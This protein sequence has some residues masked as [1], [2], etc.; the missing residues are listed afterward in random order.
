MSELSRILPHLGHVIRE[1]VIREDRIG[2]LHVQDLIHIFRKRRIAWDIL[3]LYTGIAVYP[4]REVFLHRGLLSYGTKISIRK[5]L[6]CHTLGTVLFSPVLQAVSCSGELL[7][8]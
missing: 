7:A 3:S 8:E 5:S 6:L 1:I 2:E 4:R